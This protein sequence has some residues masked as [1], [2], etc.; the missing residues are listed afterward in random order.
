MGRTVVTF[1]SGLQDT[2]EG[3]AMLGWSKGQGPQ[4]QLTGKRC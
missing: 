2:G 4:A 1:R 3:W